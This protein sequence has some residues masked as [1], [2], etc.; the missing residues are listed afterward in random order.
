MAYDV[1]DVFE[2]IELDLIRKMKKSLSH[3][4]KDEDDLEIEYNQW[5]VE[6]LKAFEEFKKRNPNLFKGKFS[7]VNSKITDS[8]KGEYKSGRL[9]QERLYLE[10]IK[11]GYK[12]KKNP[13]LGGDFFK[14]NDRKLTS[15][16][17]SVTN[18]MTKAETS[19]LRRTNDLY[20]QTILKTQTFLNSGAETL[21][22]AIDM[23]TKDFLAVGINSIQYANGRMVN[24]RS[25]SE[26]ALRTANTRAQ[27]MGEGSMRE[28][29]GEHLVKMSSYG[30]CSETCLP[31]QG[32]VYIDDVYSG[33]K[34]GD[35]DYPLL[36]TAMSGGAFH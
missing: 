25:Y 13:R 14:I 27:L 35:G 29:L 36:S 30:K 23:A 15:L 6:Q 1:A 31:F 7:E 5:Q 20:R 17:K 18:D 32:Q 11:K 26:M 12:S 22:Q 19:L 28:E 3:H 4:F 9:R 21:D 16:V 24:I 10:A 34:Q 33:G 2:E 8:I